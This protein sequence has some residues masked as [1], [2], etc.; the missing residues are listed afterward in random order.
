MH[1]KLLLLSAL[2]STAF[3]QMPPMPNMPGMSGMA[4]MSHMN[5]NRAGMYLMNMSSG[6]AMNPYSWQMPMK[7]T[8]AGTWNLMFMSQVFLVNTQ[9]SGPRG[10]DKFYSTNWFM[11]S[12]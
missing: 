1:R 10:A 12:A 7:M 4:G 3:A 6:T 2:C 8:E 5:M 9:Q 11:A